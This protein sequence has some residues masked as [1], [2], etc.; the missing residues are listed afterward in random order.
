MSSRSG[1]L[2]F[3][4]VGKDELVFEADLSKPLR[5]SQHDPQAQTSSGNTFPFSSDTTYSSVV[6]V[7]DT[8]TDTTVSTDIDTDT[9]TM[10]SQKM[11][12]RTCTSLYCIPHWILWKSG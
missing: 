12:M 2:V 7:W 8:N 5:F 4:I 10:V 11:T 1:A 6:T 9:D 3:A